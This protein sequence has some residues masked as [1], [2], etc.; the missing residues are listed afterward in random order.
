MIDSLGKVLVKMAMVVQPSAT[1][2]VTQSATGVF[3]ARS[4]SIDECYA[5]VRE[6]LKLFSSYLFLNMPI[7][8]FLTHH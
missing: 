8:T 7:V 1:D 4:R 5:N 6:S 2:V 3:R